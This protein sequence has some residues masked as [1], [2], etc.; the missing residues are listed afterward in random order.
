MIGLDA[1]LS[2]QEIKRA[3]FDMGPTKAPGPNGYLVLFY[4]AS[5]CKAG[6]VCI[7]LSV[8]FGMKS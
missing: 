2:V 1:N 6:T 3:I 8:K 4:Q 7:I 5:W